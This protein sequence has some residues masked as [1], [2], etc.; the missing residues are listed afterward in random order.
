MSAL[1]FGG[2]CVSRPGAAG[3][4]AFNG[5]DG[6]LAAGTYFVS[7]TG[8][9]ST[10]A[11]GWSVVSASVNLGAGQLSVRYG[12]VV[13]TPTPGEFV[14]PCG[15]DAGDVDV[16][17]AAD[18]ELEARVALGPVA[19]DLGGHDLGIFLRDGAVE[20]DGLA[21]SSAEEHADGLSPYFCEG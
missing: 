13:N 18:L 17:I 11:A 9:N 8:Y 14:E 20:S 16:G 3:G 5:R 6:S 12:T 15:A 19:G 1:S 10:F 7:F 4:T 2:G 21:V